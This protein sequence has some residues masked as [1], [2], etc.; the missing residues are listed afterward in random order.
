ME[1][2]VQARDFTLTEGLT[3]AIVAAAKHY[4]HT[5]RRSVRK[6]AVRVYDLNGPR[7]GADKGCLVVADLAD[8]RVIVS[9]DVDSDLYRAIPRAFAKLKRGTQARRQRLQARRRAAAAATRG[10]VALAPP[11][12]ALPAT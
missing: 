10:F 2:D 1:I 11:R 12:G 3:A 6:V 7:G 8:G 9:S 5:F 4:G